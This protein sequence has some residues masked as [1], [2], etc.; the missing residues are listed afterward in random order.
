MVVKRCTHAVAPMLWWTGDGAG[1]AH[2]LYA[3]AETGSETSSV[4]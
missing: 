3:A 1:F 4:Q 2:R